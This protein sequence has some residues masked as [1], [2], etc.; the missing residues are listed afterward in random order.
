MLSVRI[1]YIHH[2]LL[3]V[4]DI[5]RAAAFYTALGM[6]RVPSLSSS[7]AWLKFGPNELHLWQTDAQHAYNGWRHEPS[8]HFAIEGDDIHEFERRIPEL[9]GE[10]LQEPRQRPHDGSWYL[11]ALD[12]DGNRFEITQHE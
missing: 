1:R 2:L 6:E 7:I 5:E 3:P 4:Q 12:P 8:P 10:V 11:F 9:G